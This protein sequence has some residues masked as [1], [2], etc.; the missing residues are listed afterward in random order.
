MKLL[1]IHRI[2]TGVTFKQ[3][4]GDLLKKSWVEGENGDLDALYWLNGKRFEKLTENSWAVIVRG[5]AK[6]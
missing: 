4:K 6:L 1:I 2:S 3:A 5:E